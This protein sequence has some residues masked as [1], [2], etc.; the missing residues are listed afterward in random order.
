[1]PVTVTTRKAADRARVI[2]LFLP[3]P[4]DVIDRYQYQ[5][6]LM[7]NNPE[8]SQSRL[9]R[10]WAIAQLCHIS[11]QVPCPA[12]CSPMPLTADATKVNNNRCFILFITISFL[13]A[14]LCGSGGKGDGQNKARIGLFK[15][16]SPKQN[17]A[18]SRCLC[19]QTREVGAIVYA[20]AVGYFLHGKA[21]MDE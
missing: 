2:R 18:D 15:V 3:M 14:K 6:R 13:P 5:C 11:W 9:D 8:T 17:R 19:E 20:E 21:G 4:F 1:M 12:M 7:W 10:T 16:S